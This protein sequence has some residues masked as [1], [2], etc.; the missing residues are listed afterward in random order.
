MPAVI[1]TRK[2]VARALKAFRVAYTAL[3][4]DTARR[5]ASEV[6]AAA[7]PDGIVQPREAERIAQRASAIL[8]A[9]YVDGQGR[10]VTPDGTP[11]SPYARLLLGACAWVTRE[12]VR[13]QAAWMRAN[14]PEDIQRWL[15]RA[16]RPAKE[17]AS[18]RR[19]QL[20]IVREVEN[21]LWARMTP[22]DLRARIVA[23]NPLAQ[24]DAP[25]TWVDP[26]GYTLNERIWR[27]DAD[28]RARLNAYLRDQIA[29][30]NGALNIARGLEQFLVPGREALRT[31]RPYGTDASFNT[32]RL[33]R[34]EIS[35]ANNAA[36]MASARMNPYVTG[37]E[38]HRSGNG[39]PNCPICGPL[40]KKYKLE[41]APT[42]PAHPHCMCYLSS[43]VTDN[44][45]A[46]ADQ[47]RAI[48]Q[49][50]RLPSTTP[51]LADTF[52]REL[53]A[54]GLWALLPQVERMLGLPE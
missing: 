22:E 1:V 36:A 4:T 31:S 26:N 18:R 11:V 24:Y 51:L 8:R 52:T 50:E 7:G 35:H 27:A 17:M 49:A 42:P 16:E 37:V 23:D 34:T 20:T 46:V 6:V 43:I 45:D 40:A 39:D 54:V 19:V 25:H 32:M 33:A 41:D 48:M 28:T 12:Q 2:P 13:K 5:I 38:W 15:R 44:A 21:P 30:G 29:N 3:L 9:V 14:V 47:I 53:L 10:A